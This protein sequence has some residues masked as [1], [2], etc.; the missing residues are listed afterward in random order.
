MLACNIIVCIFKMLCIYPI[1]YNFSFFRS[2][3]KCTAHKAWRRRLSVLIIIGS[4]SPKECKG[5]RSLFLLFNRVQDPR[6][7]K[8]KNVSLIYLWRHEYPKPGF[9]V[10]ISCGI[11]L[12]YYGKIG[13]W[14]LKALVEQGFFRFFLPYLIVFFVEVSIIT[15]KNHPI[16]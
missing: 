9:R 11:L 15:L 12:K 13:C 14:K 8:Q 5:T 16:Y 4:G 6:H 2:L 10:W 1:L 7:L 3:W